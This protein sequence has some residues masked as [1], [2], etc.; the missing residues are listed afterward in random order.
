MNVDIRF[1]FLLLDLFLKIIEYGDCSSV[2]RAL[3]CGS[4][5]RGF[6]SHQSPKKGY[7]SKICIWS[8]EGGEMGRRASFRN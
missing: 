1:G 6:D 7:L 4:S 5:C 3:D 8:S 2:G